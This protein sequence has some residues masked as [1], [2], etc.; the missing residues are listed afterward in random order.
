MFL[1]PQKEDTILYAGHQVG[2]DERTD[3]EDL[4]YQ[5]QDMKIRCAVMHLFF[6]VTK[7]WTRGNLEERWTLPEEEVSQ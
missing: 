4:F 2:T 1:E 5:S 3:V 6:F 7:E